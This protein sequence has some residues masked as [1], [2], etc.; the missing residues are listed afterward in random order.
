MN[1]SI[2]ISYVKPN[3]LFFIKLDEFFK[4]VNNKDQVRSFRKCHHLKFHTH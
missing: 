2:R 4:I 3:R 1:Q